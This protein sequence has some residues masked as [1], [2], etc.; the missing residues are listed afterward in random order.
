VFGLL[1]REKFQEIFQGWN[2]YAK[3]ANSYKL[4]KSLINEIKFILN[5]LNK[6]TKKRKNKNKIKNKS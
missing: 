3:W 2:A 4:R 1:S 5:K 6:K